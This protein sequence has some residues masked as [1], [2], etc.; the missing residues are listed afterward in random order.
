[1][2]FEVKLGDT[3]FIYINRGRSKAGNHKQGSGQQ[4]FVTT[5]H[6]NNVW[7][8][9]CCHGDMSISRECDSETNM[10]NE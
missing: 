5:I 8:T 9:T 7:V 4:G 10:P 2:K 3:H 6:V 1:L